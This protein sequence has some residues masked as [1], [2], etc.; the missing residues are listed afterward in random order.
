MTET[1]I[2]QSIEAVRN[3]LGGYQL[4]V[5]MLNLRRYE[6]KRHKALDENFDCPDLLTGDETYWRARMYE[7]ETLIGRMR[8]GREKL[9]LYYHYIKGERIERAADFLGFSRRTAY[10]VHQKGLLQAAFLYE[11]TKKEGQFPRLFLHRN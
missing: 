5:D 3:F 8:N 2:N 9:V 7:I 10:R 11:K 1:K 6:R 4:C